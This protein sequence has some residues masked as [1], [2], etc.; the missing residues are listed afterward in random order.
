MSKA[1]VN[2]IVSAVHARR[3]VE[4][5]PPHEVGLAEHLRATLDGGTLAELLARFSD[6]DT[7]FDRLMRRVMW[8]AS[9]R[10]LG[11]AARIGRGVMLHHP[12]RLEIGDGVFIGDQVIVQGRFDGSCVLGNHVWIGPQSFLDAR[13]LVIEDFVG[14]GPGAKV[15]GSTH[16]G[17]PVTTPIIRTDLEIRPVRVGAEADIG[18]NAVLLPGVSIGRGAIVAAGAVVTS[19]VAEFSVV[20]GVPARFIK[21]RDGYEPPAKA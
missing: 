8:R 6:G 21:W 1:D 3:E 9:L 13:N 7:D 11:H 4:P 17:D 15:L 19:D 20:A 14:W 12:E 5:D 16:T 10:R 2:R 18:V